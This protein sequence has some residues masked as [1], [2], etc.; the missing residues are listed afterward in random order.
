MRQ[1]GIRLDLGAQAKLDIVL[2][3][4]ALSETVTV[5]APPR[6]ST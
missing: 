5:S 3:V 2:K 4:G 1:E 6:S